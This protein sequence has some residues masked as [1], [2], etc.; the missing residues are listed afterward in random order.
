MLPLF[1]WQIFER[2]HY[3]TVKSASIIELACRFLLQIKRGSTNDIDD[4]VSVAKEH[5]MIQ[6]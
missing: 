1:D 6:T 2:F 4:T 5:R 3:P